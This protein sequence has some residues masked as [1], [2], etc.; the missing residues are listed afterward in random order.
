MTH[1]K[2]AI[3]IIGLVLVGAILACTINVGG[4][5]Y[6]PNP[7]P[8]ATEAVGDLRAQVQTAVAA[9]VESGWITLVI[10]EVQLTSFLAFT[11][12]QSPDPLLTEPQA[13]LRDGQIQIYGT[14]RSGYFEAT[15]GIILAPSIDPDGK[16]QLEII[17]ADFG[18][19]PVPD[20]LKDAVTAIVSEAYTGALGPVT[21]GFRLETIEIRD[22]VMILFGRVR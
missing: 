15:A 20:G 14:A 16:L 17:S 22:G 7:I 4:P 19:L 21:T 10:S 13:Y 1:K 2:H 9:G 11:L 5:D 3:G 6:P 8:V 12:E 18:P